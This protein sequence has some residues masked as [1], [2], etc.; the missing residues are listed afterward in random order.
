MDTSTQSTTPQ[1]PAWTQEEVMAM[2]AHLQSEINR[3][4]VV[5]STKPLK[6]A[7]PDTFDGTSSKVDSFLSQLSLFLHGKRA[8]VILDSDKI[9]I[10][11]SYLKGG[12]AGPWAQQLTKE[13]FEEGKQMTYQ[14]FISEFKKVFADP[15]PEATARFN[16]DKLKQGS[17]TADEYIASFREL[18]SKTGYNEV[19]LMEK[20][21]DG[22]STSLVDQI[23]Q[24]P[25][26]PTTLQ[27]WFDWASKLDRQWRRRDVKKKLAASSIPRQQF[28]PA[29]ARPVQPASLPVPA[30][31]PSA[32]KSTDV[33][34]MD[35]DTGRRNYGPPICFKCR[36]L[37]HIAKNCTSVVNISAMDYE[38]LKAH[39]LKEYKTTQD[40]KEK[41]G[42]GEDH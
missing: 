42:F 32:S 1:T 11:L 7:I 34:P 3:L 6:V 35:I 22:L 21:E 17:N 23:Y 10:A 33:V 39:F 15:N 27:D 16:M 31:P 20:F 30:V 13:I 29:L 4:H 37:G 25:T 18:K 24:L 19:A 38:A 14:E 36:K 41:E 40:S 12:T 8:E 26:M 9:T 5:Q 2:I 28:K